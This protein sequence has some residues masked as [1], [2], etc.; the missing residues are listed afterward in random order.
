VYSW[1]GQS[2]PVNGWTSLTV[3]VVEYSSAIVLDAKS[4]QELRRSVLD[5]RAVPVL[6]QIAKN[7][8]LK[9]DADAVRL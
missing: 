7:V 1:G 4:G 9:R 3:C 6:D 8:T 2:D 5:V